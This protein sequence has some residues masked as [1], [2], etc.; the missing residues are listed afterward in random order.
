MRSPSVRPMADFEGEIPMGEMTSDI[1]LATPPLT[2]RHHLESW[3]KS[4][5]RLQEG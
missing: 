5:G 3:A 4:R 1:I 2:L